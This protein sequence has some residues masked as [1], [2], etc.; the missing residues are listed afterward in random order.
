MSIAAVLGLRIYHDIRSHDSEYVNM[1][2]CHIYVTQL[3]W[4]ELQRHTGLDA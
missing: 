1:N 4:R 3:R 2:H